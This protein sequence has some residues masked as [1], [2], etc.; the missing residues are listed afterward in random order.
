[1]IRILMTSNETKD[2][3]LSSIPCQY[4]APA[5]FLFEKKIL[6]IISNSKKNVF[7]TIDWWVVEEIVTILI[8]CIVYVW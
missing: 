1:M 3:C 2:T 4:Q 5:L 8:V 6:C 7:A